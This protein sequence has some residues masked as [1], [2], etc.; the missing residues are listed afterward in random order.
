MK[1]VTSEY[2]E[3]DVVFL[4]VNTGEKQEEVAE[5]L[6]EQ[7]WDIR[8]L[9]DPDGKVADAFVADAIPQTIVI[10]RSG[11]IESVHVGFLGEEALKQR[12]TDE[13]EVLTVGGRI[14]TVTAEADQ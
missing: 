3:E 12:L 6:K 8:V 10:G 13:L 14:A 11:S 9:L 7:Q 4:A 2:G 1:E 5:F